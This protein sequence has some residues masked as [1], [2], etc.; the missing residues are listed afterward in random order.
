MRA[1]ISS[2]ASARMSR[3]ISVSMMP[4]ATALTRIPRGASSTASARV[5]RLDRALGRGVVALA[6]AGALRRDRRHV[7]IAP[8]RRDHRRAA[9]RQQSTTPPRLTVRTAVEVRRLA[10]A[11]QRVAGDAGAA[12]QD[13]DGPQLALRLLDEASHLSC[14][15]DVR[16]VHEHPLAEHFGLTRD[17][18]GTRLL[19]TKV[20]AHG[21]T[22]PGQFEDD[23][24]ADS[25]RAPCHQRYARLAHASPRE[26][27]A[28]T[29]Q[30]AAPRTN[31]VAVPGGFPEPVCLSD[32]FS[33]H[34]AG[35]P[36]SAGACHGEPVCLSDRFALPPAGSPPSARCGHRKPVC[37][38]DQF[39]PNRAGCTRSAGYNHLEAVR[40]L[41]PV[42]AHPNREAPHCRVQPSRTG[43][44]VR[45]VH[46]HFSREAPRCWAQPPRTGLPV[47]QVLAH[48]GREP[49]CR[50][51]SP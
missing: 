21:V 28:N 44:P 24:A 19:I 37:L 51:Q 29:G 16:L 26:I 46:T 13:L 5:K 35:S 11:E 15:G 36:P 23:R 12:D 1:R 27:H 9:C 32:R 43:P 41:R 14:V 7:T 34:L 25:A 8:R 39:A 17:F 6:A 10:R 40:L 3:V 20:D 38:S 49:L 4:G 18:G 45:Q 50:V 31:P 33:A 42:R 30:P 22:T 2:G 48:L 47:R